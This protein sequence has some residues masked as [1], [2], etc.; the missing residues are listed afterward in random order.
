MEIKK[1]PT[2]REAIS[3]SSTRRV[4]LS[5]PSRL[6]GSLALQNEDDR[7]GMIENCELIIFNSQ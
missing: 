7:L 2:Q 4:V 6:D 1:E 3:V 5:L